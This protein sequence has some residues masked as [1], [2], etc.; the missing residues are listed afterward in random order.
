MIDCAADSRRR[1]GPD[2]RSARPIYGWRQLELTPILLVDRDGSW[3][4]LI[5]ER[6]SAE[7]AAAIARAQSAMFTPASAVAQLIEAKV[8]L[9]RASL[10][11]APPSSLPSALNGKPITDQPHRA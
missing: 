5:A 10:T 9:E 3:T 6:E 7:H 2:H 1:L 11:P 4:A 8:D